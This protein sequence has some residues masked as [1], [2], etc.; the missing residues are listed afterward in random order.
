M[1]SKKE[2]LLRLIDVEIRLEEI[3][4]KITKPKKTVKKTT[5]KTKK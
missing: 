2:L 1:I 3:E 5:R 4:E